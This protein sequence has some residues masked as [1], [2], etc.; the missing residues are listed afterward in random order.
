MVVQ[1]P[2]VRMLTAKSSATE[3]VDHA[4]E[5]GVRIL[6]CENSMRSAGLEEKDLAAGVETVPAAIAHLAQRQ[7]GGWAYARL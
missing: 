5:L 3:A 4:R 6:A 1:G 7:W 2:G